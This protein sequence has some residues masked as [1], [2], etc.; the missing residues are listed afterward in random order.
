MIF[1]FAG[2]L[3][4]VGKFNRLG[5]IATINRRGASF[6]VVAIGR[7]NI[8]IAGREF[9][10]LI[11]KLVAFGEVEFDAVGECLSR[12]ILR[13]AEFYAIDGVSCRLLEVKFFIGGSP[14]RYRVAQRQFLNAVVADFDIRA[15]CRADC[16]IRS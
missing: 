8:V 14:N 6:L 9:H 10:R 12:R 1:I 16:V 5:G 7:G 13:R 3:R 11:S 2:N 4:I 15:T